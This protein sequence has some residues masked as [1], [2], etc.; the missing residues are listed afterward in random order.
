MEIGKAVEM[1]K[2]ELRLMVEGR[3]GQLGM[4]AVRGGSLPSRWW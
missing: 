1:K 3:K 4:Q 2:G